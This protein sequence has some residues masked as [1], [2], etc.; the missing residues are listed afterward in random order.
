MI[1]NAGLDVVVNIY[2]EI[3]EDLGER[4][5]WDKANNYAISVSWTF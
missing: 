4:K 5:Q 1:Y 2:E 3:W